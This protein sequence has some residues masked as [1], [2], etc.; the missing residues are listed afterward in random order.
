MKPEK[1][2]VKVIGTA[3]DAGIPQVNCKCTHCL[4]ARSDHDFT[5][6]AASLA[7]LFPE[8]NEWIL[9]DATP[10]ICEQIERV[11]SAYPQM[12]LMNS[13]L[14][15]HA[16]MGHYT[17]LMY[18]GKEAISAQ[19]MPVYAGSGMEDFL[20]SNAPWRQ[21]VELHNITIQQLRDGLPQSELGLTS[22]ALT[23]TPVEVPHRNEYA[24]TFGF[25]LSGPHKKLLYIPDIDR[26][27]EWRYQLAEIASTVD[28]C[29]LDATFFSQQELAVRGRSYSEVPHPL[30]V[31][32]MDLLQSVVNE[33]ETDVCFTHFNHTNPV[34]CKDSE[35]RKHVEDRGFRIA[36]E[37]MEFHL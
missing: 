10:D 8:S 3:Q 36:E 28:I 5:R 11:Q 27:E 21:L 25:L 20:R 19:A 13:V 18:L 4:R 33:G 9:I 14:L 32:T 12:G 30:L 6:Y 7:V 16:H 1:V 24:E 29:I 15:T 26:W 37:G 34:I 31:D 2:V 23:I 22:T 17:G 35:E